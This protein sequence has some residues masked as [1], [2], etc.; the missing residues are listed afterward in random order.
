MRI[1]L[2]QRYV[3]NRELFQEPGARIQ[4]AIFQKAKKTF[5]LSMLRNLL[6]ITDDIL[7]AI[8][9]EIVT[10]KKCFDFFQIPMG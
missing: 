3:K 8:D 6:K 2:F 1:I 4:K 10:F 9:F 5:V 7:Y